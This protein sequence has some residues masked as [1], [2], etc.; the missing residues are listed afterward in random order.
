M[1]SRS[2]LRALGFA[3]LAALAVIPWQL[4]LGPRLGYHDAALFFALA[5]ASLY[6]VAIAPDPRRALV[7]LAAGVPLVGGALVLGLFLGSPRAT[8]VAAGVALAVVRSGVLYRRG[9]AR[10]LV[11][12]AGLL[13][14]GALAA[15]LLGGPTT[16]GPALALWAF[17]LVQSLYFLVADGEPRREA[18]RSDD[19]FEEARGRLEELLA[20]G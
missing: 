18:G 10:S 9:L 8:L 2:F 15:L 1:T 6:G 7:A 14:V 3:A 19:P 4:V 11:A 16:L 13:F 12:E 5:S 20:E 17:Y